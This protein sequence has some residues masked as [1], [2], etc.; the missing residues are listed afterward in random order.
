MVRAKGVVL[1]AAIS[2]AAASGVCDKNNYFQTSTTDGANMMNNLVVAAVIDAYNAA[3]EVGDGTHSTTSAARTAMGSVGQTADDGFVADATAVSTYNTDSDVN[4]AA[5][6]TALV[7]RAQNTAALATA[8]EGLSLT[9]ITDKTNMQGAANRIAFGYKNGA[10]KATTAVNGASLG[11]TPA[12]TLVATRDAAKALQTAYGEDLGRI[13]LVDTS[14]SASDTRVLLG[15]AA[16]NTELRNQILILD[17]TK[18]TTSEALKY[19]ATEIAEGYV[20]GAKAVVDAIYASFTEVGYLS[21][22]AP[23]ASNLVSGRLNAALGANTVPKLNPNLGAMLDSATPTGCGSCAY[24]FYKA[25]FNAVTAAARNDNELKCGLYVVDPAVENVLAY[26]IWGASVGPAETTGWSKSLTTHIM[27]SAACIS[28]IQPAIDAFNLCAE[29]GMDIKT[30]ASIK[31]CTP[32]SLLT[33]DGTYGLYETVMNKALLGTALPAAFVADYSDLP[34]RTCVDT[35][36]SSVTTANSGKALYDSTGTITTRI[37]QDAGVGLPADFF[38]AGSGH[39]ADAAGP[40]VP[41]LD[42][43]QVCA[44]T[45]YMINKKKTIHASANEKILMNALKPYEAIVRCSIAN[46]INTATP[47][48]TTPAWETCLKVYSPLFTYKT[49]YS[50]SAAST[51]LGRCIHSLGGAVNT[52]SG[53]CTAGNDVFS[54]AAGTCMNSLNTTVSGTVAYGSDTTSALI[55]FFQC[56]GVNLTRPATVCSSAEI[57]ALS[58]IRK[59]YVPVIEIAMATAGTGDAGAVAAV[60][61]IMADT[62]LWAGVGDVTCRSCY[63]KLV[64]ELKHEMTTDDKNLCS[65]PYST[66]CK[67]TRVTEALTRFQTCSG[68]GLTSASANTCTAA[69]WDILLNGRLQADTFNLLLPSVS[70]SL[71]QAQFHFEELMT[72]LKAANLAKT[73]RCDH[74]F[75]VLVSDLYSLSLANKLICQA[76]IDSGACFAVAASAFTKFTACSGHTFYFSAATSTNTTTTTTTT[77]LAPISSETTTDAPADR[78][79]TKAVRT[80]HF[81]MASLIAIMAI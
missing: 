81:V 38:K 13:V 5:T 25:V 39:C 18:I 44:G 72:T 21:T 14:G 2:R 17:P 61:A 16:H 12:A 55:Q 4:I 41:L 59:T 68:F 42:T 10:E 77:T 6:R 63:A 46:S 54:V 27:N 19:V 75:E 33:L 62:D 45:T 64:A 71:G 32:E 37:C 34:C 8:I 58:S 67:S 15:T 24:N 73:F 56:S 74:C 50:I 20:A 78:E 1:S 52:A 66:E 30:A 65:N 3:S 49:D 70:A 35:L 53:T 47:T 76:N 36:I 26:N 79:V 57:A 23:L 31:M 60:T 51:N 22:N 40:I 7:G 80:T 48:A 28:T 69:E 43:F 9:D 11:V 29:N